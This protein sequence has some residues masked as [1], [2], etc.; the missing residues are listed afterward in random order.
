MTIEVLEYLDRIGAT[1]RVGD[2]RVIARNAAEL[3]G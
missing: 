1:R 2:A 3:F